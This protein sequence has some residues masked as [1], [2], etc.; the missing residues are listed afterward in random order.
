MAPQLSFFLLA[1]ISSVSSTAEMLYPIRNDHVST[2]SILINQCGNSSTEVIHTHSLS[3]YTASIQQLSSELSSRRPSYSKGRA[4]EGLDGENIWQL[5]H[6]DENNSSSRSGWKLVPIPHLSPAK[7]EESRSFTSFAQEN[8]AIKWII[9]IAAIFLLFLLLLFRIYK[10]C[11]G[12]VVLPE[13]GDLHEPLLLHSA[14]V[15]V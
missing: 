5:V 14:D 11:C 15:S 2:A 4:R 13:E 7:E 3:Q 6:T 10:R 1:L 8:P 12:S 9:S